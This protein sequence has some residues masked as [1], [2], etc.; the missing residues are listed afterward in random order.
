MALIKERAEC[1][2]HGKEALKSWKM[3]LEAEKRK[4]EEDLEAERALGV[5]KDS[6]K[7]SKKRG[8]K[9]M[10]LLSKLIWTPRTLSSAEP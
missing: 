2:K 5:D 9:T 10:S 7:R 3:S 6:L 8:R 1:E 4:V